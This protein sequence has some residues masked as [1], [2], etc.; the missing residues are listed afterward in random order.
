MGHS[1]DL[2]LH[3]FH[4]SY[5]HRNFQKL[6]TTTLN[7]LLAYG[8][9]WDSVLSTCDDIFICLECFNLI[10]N[11][12]SDLLVPLKKLRVHQFKSPWLSN[13]SFAKIRCLHDIYHRGALISGSASD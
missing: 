10:M 3:L 4:T 1:F 5:L 13:D 12:L 9:I 11:G 8:G 6:D 2:P 7:E